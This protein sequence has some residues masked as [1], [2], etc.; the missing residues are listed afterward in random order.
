MICFHINHFS[1]LLKKKSYISGQTDN[2]I[3]AL[4]E[5]PALVPS[6][7]MVVCNDPYPEFQGI[8][9]LL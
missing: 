5:D 2:S 4:A 6:H 9:C 1:I 7:H 3:V 8:Q